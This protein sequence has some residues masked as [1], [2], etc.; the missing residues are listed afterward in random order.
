GLVRRRE[1]EPY[2]SRHPLAFLVEA[3]DDICYA[4]IDIEDGYEL[5][6]LTF[7][8]AKDALVPIA[9][10]DVD[11]DAS[12]EPREQIGKLR[13][14]AIGKLVEAAAAVFLENE[15]ALLDGSFEEELLKVT[16]FRAEV[17]GVL[18]LAREKLYSSEKKNR[19]EIAGSQIIGGLLDIFSQIVVDLE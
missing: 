7:P 5:G 19:L 11:L 6:Y 3:A 15:P 16:P 8:E 13:A 10:S 14:V 4:I 17:D 12:A 1:H 2:W 9:G 18:K